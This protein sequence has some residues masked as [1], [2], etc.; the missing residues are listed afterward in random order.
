MPS[1]RS[2]STRRTASTSCATRPRTC[3]RR[4]CRRITP[5]R[6]SASARPIT[7]GFYYDFDVAEPVHARGPAGAREGDAARSSAR[8]SGSC[9]ASSPTTRPAPSSPTSRT[10][11]ELIGLKGG[12]RRRRRR[13]SRRGRRRR[14]D[15]LRQ[16]AT[17]TARP[18]WKDLCR[19]PHVPNTR[20]IGNGCAAD[21]Q[22]PPPTGAGSEK[23]PQLQRIY[24][25]AWPTQG[26][27]AGLP[28]TGSR[29]PRS[30]TTASSAPSST[31]SRFP[32]EIGS[33]LAVFHPKGGI[34]RQ[35]MED[36]A[37]R[38]H[39]EER[40]RVRLHP[41]HHQGRTCSRLRPP[42]VLRGRA[43]S[44]RCTRRGRD[45][46]AVPSRAGLLPQADELPDAQPDLPVARP[47]AT[48]SCRCG[49][50]SSAPS[51][52]TRSRASCTASPGCAA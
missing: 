44:R 10:S 13:R 19:G 42:A 45:E 34:I 12:G 26:R 41:A 8:A 40:L 22:S 46:T 35:E 23:N 20:L 7:D 11:C 21:A 43:C 29:R 4:R 1:N 2:P 36:Y 37:R 39:I 9:A 47:L 24:G 25:T 51:T 3:S 15:H 6:S 52:A 31:C 33:G 48:A 14:A 49:C 16:R 38:R 17:A 5:R 32:E 28:A 18:V 50:S 27:A 30:A